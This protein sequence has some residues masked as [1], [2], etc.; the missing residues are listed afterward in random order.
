MNVEN[1]KI[2]AREYLADAV[3]QI[4]DTTPLQTRIL[5]ASFLIG[6]FYGVTEILALVDL[7]AYCELGIETKS[8][9]ERVSAFTEQIWRI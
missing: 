6:K 2:L 5:N 9:R 7:D 3:R 4:D 8:D 1:L